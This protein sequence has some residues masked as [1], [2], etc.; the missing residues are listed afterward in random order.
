MK[1]SFNTFLLLNFSLLLIF[2]GFGIPIS[3]FEAHVVN[4]IAKIEPPPCEQQQVGSMGFWQTH[5]EFWIFPQTLGTNLVANASDAEL[6]FDLPNNV[7]EN[8]LRKQLLALKF[9]IAYFGVGN[10][11]VPGD[12]I[13]I[14]QL[15]AEADA[16]LSQD[17]LPADSV[18]EEMKN[19]VEAVN[20]AGTV[21]VCDGTPIISL[22]NPPTEEGTASVILISSSLEF[23]G[24]GSEENYSHDQTSESIEGSSIEESTT[25][26][27]PVVPNLPDPNEPVIDNSLN[28]TGDSIET[29]NPPPPPAETPPAPPPPP[30]ET[31][32]P[33]DDPPTE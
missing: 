17:P 31:P 20:T 15:A 33:P 25:T 32:P 24:G 5:E 28:N 4:V 12:T 2:A 26:E 14:S 10:A 22:G 23:V 19:R 18:L 8:K 7:M 13:T 6:V 16:L 21:Q 11:L 30:S 9:N 27:E 1:K 29:E 3:A